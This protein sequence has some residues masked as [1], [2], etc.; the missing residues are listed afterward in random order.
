MSESAHDEQRFLQLI[1]MFQLAAMQQMGKTAS[2]V[3]GEVERDLEAAQHSIDMLETLERKSQGNR[4]ALEDEFLKK[5]L[6]ELRMNFVDETSRAT[7][8]EET[9]GAKETEAP[10]SA[11]EGGDATGEESPNDAS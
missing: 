9:A 1:A 5:A 4:T 6:F 7:A 11:P 2:P 3:T 10:E 8:E